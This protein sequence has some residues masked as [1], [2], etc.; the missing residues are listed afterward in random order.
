M[1][2]M[3]RFFFV[4][5]RALPLFLHKSKTDEPQAA[6]YDF[7]YFVVCMATCDFPGG[8]FCMIPL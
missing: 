2:I 6:C 4:S 3:Q 1:H 5:S 8:L 7:T